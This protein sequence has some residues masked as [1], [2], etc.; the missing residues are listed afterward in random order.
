MQIPDHNHESMNVILK[1]N[2]P[3]C[4]LAPVVVIAIS[5]DVE[6]IAKDRIIIVK[7]PK[8]NVNFVYIKIAIFYAD[9][10]RSV[11]CLFVVCLPASRH[12]ICMSE[13]QI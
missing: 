9:A 6:S 11:S 2:L 7:M 12:M 10:G 1:R 5:L 8:C 4:F 13:Y 3:P